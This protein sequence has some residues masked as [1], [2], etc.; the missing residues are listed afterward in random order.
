MTPSRRRRRR[1]R[2]PVRS[3]AAA[4][5]VCVLAA[6]FLL[7]VTVPGKRADSRAFATASACVGDEPALECRKTIEGTVK[8]TETV[9][10]GKTTHYWLTITGR[11]GDTHRAEMNGPASVFGR[12]R[13]GDPV[14]ATY[15]RGKIRFV[16]FRGTVQLT[17]DQPKDAYRLPFACGMGLLALG[18]TFAWLTYWMVRQVGRHPARYAWQATV[19]PCAGVLTGIVAF[20]APMV[21]DTMPTALVLTG[22]G[23]VPVV[24]GALW[25]IRVRRRQSEE[26]EIA[27]VVPEREECV[28]GGV[29]ARTPYGGELI[30]AYL[31]VGPGLLAVTPDPEGRA[32]RRVLPR[33][34]VVERVRVPYWSDPSGVTAETR[35]WRKALR[36]VV[37]VCRDGDD[38]V[39]IGVQRKHVPW[40]LG[41]LQGP[42]APGEPQAPAT[43]SESRA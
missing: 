36:Q 33:T 22:A 28:E 4:S 19:L 21:T 35:G 34:L 29:A 5:L 1:R 8:G 42:A 39:L 25:R 15:W 43:A 11:G 12:V 13:P 16:D 20:V 38:E 40:V 9:P 32:L 37:L 7:F 10:R 24:L 30:G 14:K 31:V 17:A 2:H 41:A 18:G 23:T 3:A 26:F 27:P 6:L